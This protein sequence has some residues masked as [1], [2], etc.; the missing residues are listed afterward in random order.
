[1]NS[2]STVNYTDVE[3]SD[4]ANI[5]L[6]MVFELEN[7]NKTTRRRKLSM[8]IS[9]SSSH[10]SSLSNSFNEDEFILT[11]PSGRYNH[12]NA[13]SM[14]SSTKNP[15]RRTGSKTF[16]NSMSND[17][18]PPEMINEGNDDEN[19][20]MYYNGSFHSCQQNVLSPSGKVAS[21]S[22]NTKQV[23]R[24][25]TRSF[26]TTPMMMR[27]PPPLPFSLSPP[28]PIKMTK[29]PPHLV[30]DFSTSNS[31]NNNSRYSD[32]PPLTTLTA[33]TP[34]DAT[35]RHETQKHDD[36]R[37]FGSNDEERIFNPTPMHM[38]STGATTTT[39]SYG[40]SKKSRSTI[41]DTSTSATRNFLS[42][43]M[44]PFI[45]STPIRTPESLTTIQQKRKRPHPPVL[46]RRKKSNV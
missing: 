8:P 29:L 14:I 26:T 45:Y 18:E 39:R 1:M 42:S 22:D 27:P 17:D 23:A 41:I 33:T 19:E 34:L 10:S 20:V 2:K 37:A 25:R 4:E 9:H 3:K 24:K 13:D 30:G 40:S 11:L 16:P 15:Y 36:E 21:A 6:S 28:S 35:S 5:S 7:G 46:Q 38:Q 43:I 32:V 31:N 44:S 12:D